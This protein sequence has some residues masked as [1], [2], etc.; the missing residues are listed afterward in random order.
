MAKKALP[1][2]T[3]LLEVLI[4]TTVLSVGILACLNVLS[5]A[6]HV[7]KH[8]AELEEIQAAMDQTLF[9]KFL[10]PSSVDL[11]SGVISLEQDRKRPFTA[12]LEVES[13]SQESG[14]EDEKKKAE[15]QRANQRQNVPPVKKSLP[16]SVEFFN[17]DFLVERTK[18][19][20]PIYDFNAF[21]FRYG[22]KKN[23]L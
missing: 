1:C 20:K 16:S 21:L 12:K 9:E 7:S 15:A 2:G 13:M 6:M 22:Q 4:A 10:D 19:H 18:T 11:A 23:A 17:A 5:A 3:L 14:G 8:T